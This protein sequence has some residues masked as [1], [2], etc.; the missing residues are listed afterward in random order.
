MK[1][2]LILSVVMTLVLVISMSTATF[3]WYTSNSTVTATVAQ[4]T[5]ASSSGSLNISIT[6][7]D[8]ATLD[9]ESKFDVSATLPADFAINPVCPNGAL[10]SNATPNG[11]F[12]TGIIDGKSKEHK[13]SVVNALSGYVVSGTILIS[14]AD[15]NLAEGLTIPTVL[16][17]VTCADENIAWAIFD[18]SNNLYATSQ[19]SYITSAIS[20]ETVKTAADYFTNVE[21]TAEYSQFS[22]AK[23]GDT[24]L[25][26]YIWFDGATTVNAH[27][28]N[29]ASV[30]FE[31]G[32]VE[33]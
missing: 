12:A 5:A 23:A 3:A 28:G 7:N 20:G 26:Y 21:A 13:L 2:S 1:K 24:I 30:S 29:V 31:F 22:V 27:Q 6:S 11:M 18:S 15:E 4:I 14:N 16:K 10:T 8:G 17:S 9:N 19:F 25:S 33:A 32:I